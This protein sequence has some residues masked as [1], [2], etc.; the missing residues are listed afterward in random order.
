MTSPRPPLDRVALERVLSRASQLH[1]QQSEEPTG[2]LSDDQILELGKEVGLSPDALRQAIAEERGRAGLPVAR[3]LR[4]AWFGATTIA[5]TRVVPGTPAAAIANLDE[6]MRG[7][8]SFDVKRRY[9]DGM[10]WEPKRGFFDT[11]KSQLA[12][13]NIGSHLRAA[14]DIAVTVVAVDAQ[15]SHVRVEAS[16]AQAR[17]RAVTGTTVVSGLGIATAAAGLALVPLSP[18]IIVSPIAMIAFV[19]LYGIR[20]SHHAVVIRASTALEQ[21]LDRVEFGA[22]AK[23]AKGFVEKLLGQ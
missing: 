15:R 16:I 4:G 2:A 11:M 19:A 5:S 18:A 1:G 7:E 3:G 13:P 22:P 9:A 23:R 14:D 6:L 12:G 21:L 20:R 10:Q 8:L 17:G